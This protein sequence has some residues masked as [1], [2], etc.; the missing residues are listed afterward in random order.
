MNNE[1]GLN[2]G[3]HEMAHALHL[4]NATTNEEYGFLDDD[5]L[6]VWTDLCYKEIDKMKG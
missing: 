6:K 1:D 2:L 4:E 5:V 3:L